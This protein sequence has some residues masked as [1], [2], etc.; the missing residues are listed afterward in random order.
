MLRTLDTFAGRVIALSAILGTLGLITE[1]VVILI[2]VTGRYFGAPLTG[3]QDITQMAMVVLVFGGMALCDRQGGHIAV[4]IFE[5]AMP[6]WMIRV[7]DFLAAVI[8]ALIFA[9]IAWQMW[10]SATISQMLNLATNIIYL[11]KDWF[12][13]YVVVCSVIAAFGMTLRA[14]ALLGGAPP[15]HAEGHVK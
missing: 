12:Q 15:R 7:T 11:P 6:L 14:L 1:V 5:R 3:A 8:G 10:K 2:D 9:G 4:D 13:Y